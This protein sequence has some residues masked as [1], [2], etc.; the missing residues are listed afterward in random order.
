MSLS[1]TDSAKVVALI[2]GGN[3]RRY[4]ASV[5]GIPRLTVQ[6]VYLA[7]ERQKDIPGDPVQGENER[8]AK[9]PELL[10]QHHVERLRF[11]HNH[12]NWNLGEWRQVFFTDESRFSLQMDV[13]ECGEEKE[14]VFLHVPSV[15]VSLSKVDQSWYGMAFRMK[16]PQNLFSLMENLSDDDGEIDAIESLEDGDFSSSYCAS[17]I[18]SSSDGEDEHFDCCCPTHFQVMVT[19]VAQAVARLPADQ[20]LRSGALEATIICFNCSACGVC[21][22]KS[23][24]SPRVSDI[25]STRVPIEVNKRMVDGFLSMRKGMAGMKTFVLQWL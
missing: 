1:P 20:E 6:R 25:D 15:D 21:C 13:K 7:L 4:V 10:Q 2:E 18:E 12:A 19:E 11:A 22:A 17:S 8:P 24:T 23:N 14:N 9:G 5:L 3:S 16:L